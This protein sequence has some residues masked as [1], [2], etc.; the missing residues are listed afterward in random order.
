[1][2][3]LSKVSVGWKTIS[4]AL[5]TAFGYLSQPDVLAVLPTNV[6]A[7]ITAVGIVLGAFGIR[8]ALAKV[9]AAA[10]R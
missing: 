7:I 1:M 3:P 6:A 10:Q 4:G 5:L 8:T 2:S 9:E